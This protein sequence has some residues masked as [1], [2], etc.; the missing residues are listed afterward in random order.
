LKLIA[1][2]VEHEPQ[3]VRWLAIRSDVYS[4]PSAST[5]L[6]EQ[7]DDLLASHAPIPALD[8]RPVAVEQRAR[9]A[10]GRACARARAARAASRQEREPVPRAP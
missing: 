3:R 6:V 1:P 8:L 9:R 4:T 5:R 7:R 2:L 10:G